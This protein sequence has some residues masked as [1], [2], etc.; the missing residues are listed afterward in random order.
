MD[1][2]D[3]SYTPNHDDHSLRYSYKNQ[4]TIIWWNL[5]RFAEAMGELLGAGPIVDDPGFIE[6]GVKKEHVSGVVA[7][8]EK[9][10]MQAGEE[11][12]A[13]FLGEYKRLMTARLGLKSSKDSD[14]D[15]LFSGALDNLEAFELDFHHFFRRL[16]H[17]RLG[18][19]STPEARREN[20]AVFFHSE[21]PPRVAGEDAARE[22]LGEWLGKWRARVIEDWTE[23]AAEQ[24]ERMKAMKQMNPNFVPRGWILDEVIQR[25]EKG[26]EREVLDRIMHMALNPFEDTWE[27]NKEEQKRWVGDV[28]RLER[29]MQCSCSS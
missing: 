11:Y 25:V 29:A 13:T 14:F 28:P 20:A 24:E 10:I 16:S 23:G 3:P 7:R 15:E 6:E 22:Q 18:D 1:N 27:G 17:L 5:V 4:P 9:I 2:F 12:K 26:G 19:L 21:G 8:A